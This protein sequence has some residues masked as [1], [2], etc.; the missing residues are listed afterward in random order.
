MHFSNQQS[1]GTPQFPPT[2]NTLLVGLEPWVEPEKCEPRIQIP[3][4]ERIVKALLTEIAL[5]EPGVP[6]EQGSGV[7]LVAE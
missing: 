6:L 1:A 2:F 5:I 7:K 4:Q 3:A